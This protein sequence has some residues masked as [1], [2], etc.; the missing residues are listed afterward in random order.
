MNDAREVAGGSW[1]DKLVSER[2][3]LAI[4]VSGSTKIGTGLVVK[5]P[6]DDLLTAEKERGRANSR[7]FDG[8][9]VVAHII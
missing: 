9:F 1:R 8:Y 6:I 2:S 5:R 7:R 4:A 3:L